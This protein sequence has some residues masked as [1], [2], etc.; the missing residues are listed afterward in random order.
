M[1]PVRGLINSA[2][3]R[4]FSHLD[5]KDY[6]GGLGFTYRARVISLQVRDFCSTRQYHEI[7]TGCSFPGGFRGNAMEVLRG[8]VFDHDTTAFNDILINSWLTVAGS[9]HRYLSHVRYEPQCIVSVRPYIRL[10]A[11]SDPYP[12]RQHLQL[13]P[14]TGRQQ[15]PVYRIDPYFIR[16]YTVQPSQVSRSSTEAEKRKLGF[17]FTTQPPHPPKYQKC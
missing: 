16:P 6:M 17:P 14:R 9:H 4:D 15:R 12:Y 13:A 5:R 10:T 3:H 7:D 11:V 2:A 1:R 8:T